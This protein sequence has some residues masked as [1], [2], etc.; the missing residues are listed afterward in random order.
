MSYARFRDQLAQA[1]RPDFYPIHWLDRQVEIGMSVPICGDAS[2]MV[3]GTRVYP[4]GARVGLIRAAA[5]DME[6]LIHVL[7]PRA[8]EWGRAHGCT[9]ALIEGRH[10]WSRA[11][12]QHGWKA[13]Q[14]ALLKDI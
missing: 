9:M 2:A 5:G 6:E 10:G 7:G 12:K 1:N 13:H 11:L 4:G 8:E 14:V 3:V